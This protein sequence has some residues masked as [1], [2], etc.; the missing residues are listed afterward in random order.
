MAI[1]LETEFVMFNSLPKN[2]MTQSLVL[3]DETI[4]VYAK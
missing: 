3:R 2:T 1:A 4:H